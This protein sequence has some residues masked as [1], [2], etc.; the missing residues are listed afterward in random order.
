MHTKNIFIT[1]EILSKFINDN[2]YTSSVLLFVRVILQEVVLVLRWQTTVTKTTWGV[3][4]TLERIH[5]HV[6]EVME[7]QTVSQVSLLQFT[8]FF[9]K[10]PALTETVSYS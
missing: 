8:H 4:A 9:V 1:H 7:E 6:T 2:M 3:P 5:V 10:P